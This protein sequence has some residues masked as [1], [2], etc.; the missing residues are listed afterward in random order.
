MSKWGGVLVLSL[1]LTVAACGGSAPLPSNNGSPDGGTTTTPSSSSICPAGSACVVD[2]QQR[3]LGTLSYSYGSPILYSPRAGCFVTL[4]GSG[5][6]SDLLAYTQAGVVVQY[7]SADCTGT[8]YLVFVSTS[9]SAWSMQCY[10]V[11]NVLYM[12]TSGAA[13]P[14]M[15]GHSHYEGPQCVSGWYSTSNNIAWL[16]GKQVVDSLFPYAMPLSIVQK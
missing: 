16:S 9:S 1:G 7:G 2:A 3:E 13:V 14:N 6:A 12:A 8:P 11:G 5:T 4:V 15:V 10:P